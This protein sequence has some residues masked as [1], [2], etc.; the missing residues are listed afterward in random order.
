MF[1]VTR[2]I[3]FCYGHRL[4]DYAGKCCH[5]HGHNGRVRIALAAA[6]LDSRGMVLDFSQI[7]SA[8]GGWI[9]ENLDHRM[10]LERT[11]PAVAA[12][13]ELGEPMYLMDESPT[14]ENIAKLI[15]DVAVKHGFPVVEVRLWE[16]PH[17]WA[18]Y[19][20]AASQTNS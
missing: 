11:D 15:F 8:V 20:P 1:T 9:D 6:H 14:A 13:T 3:D 16:T 18:A 5:L 19:R 10:L 2:E 7:K 12:L 17:C 4:L